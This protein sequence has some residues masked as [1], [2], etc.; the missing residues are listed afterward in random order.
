MPGWIPTS[1]STLLDPFPAGHCS[2][3]STHPC[4]ICPLASP[5]CPSRP[6]LLVKQSNYLSSSKLGSFSFL[7]P[8]LYSSFHL[9]PITNSLL[10]ILVGFVLWPVQVVLLN[11]SYWLNSQLLFFIFKISLSFTPLLCLFI[12]TIS[13]LPPATY[14]TFPPTH[15]YWI[16]PLAGP[17][18]PS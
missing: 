13:S 4:W 5:R 17:G 18:C 14:H 6:I 1:V 16:C 9:L 3:P 10:L 8:P 7:S 11:Q 12:F 15:P 2:I